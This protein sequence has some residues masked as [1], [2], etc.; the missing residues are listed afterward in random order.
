MDTPKTK[1]QLRHYWFIYENGNIASVKKEERKEEEEE[2][3]EP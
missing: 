3:Q 2:S 1:D